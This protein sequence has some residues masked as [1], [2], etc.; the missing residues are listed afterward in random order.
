M[1]SLTRESSLVFFERPHLIFFHIHVEHPALCNKV[2]PLRHQN[3]PKQR[4]MRQSLSEQNLSSPEPSITV[5]SMPYK[6]SGS[7][8]TNAGSGPCFTLHPS[9]GGQSERMPSMYLSTTNPDASTAQ[10]THPIQQQNAAHLTAS[11]SSSSNLVHSAIRGGHRVV[12]LN[13]LPPTYF[14]PKTHYRKQ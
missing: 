9:H 5:P 11:T 4:N 10:G 3:I 6:N 13:S 12:D 14:Q 7:S 2:L 1:F 8:V